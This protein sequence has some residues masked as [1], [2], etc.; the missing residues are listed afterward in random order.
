MNLSTASSAKKP[1]ELSQREQ[2]AYNWIFWLL[3]AAFEIFLFA[4][5]L[6]PSGDGPIHI[7]LSSI[8]WKLATHSSPFYAHF[9]AIR[10]L[11]QPYSFHYYLLISLEHWFTPDRAEEI[12]VGL[13]WATLAVGFRRLA[14]ELGPG[15]RSVS[16]WVFPLLLSWPLGGGFFNYVFA[17]G[18]LLFGLV[19]YT[20]LAEDRRH[21]SSLAWLA[22]VLV[23][24]VLA[25][26][27]PI[28][29]LIFLIGID[30]IFQALHHRHTEGK[31]R[32]PI[33]SV[34]AL[35]L[36]CLAFLFP[37]LIADKAEVAGS[38]ETGIRLHLGY[39]HDMVD[40]SRLA[41]FFV[42]NIFGWIYDAALV[43]MLPVCVLLFWR[44]G[45]LAR[46]RT[47]C[48]IAPDRLLL[49]SLLY[50]FCTLFFPSDMNGSALFAVRMFFMV[51]L[52]ASPCAAWVVRSRTA[53]RTIASTGLAISLLC[54]LFACLY[55]RP[56]ARS[57]WQIEHA[58]YAMVAT[59]HR[60]CR[61]ARSLGP[62]RQLCT[63]RGL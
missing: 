56:V 44:S 35:G 50:L 22:A 43:I 17:S 45:I 26:P 8:M 60:S 33:W 41:Y 2:S 11:V 47:A 48:L 10:H 36:A 5:P 54:L 21:I 9:Y 61:R 40:G 55:L 42:N 27:L 59:D 51:W 4:L 29:L 46:L 57:Q 14:I 16:L 31:L 6:M 19:Y 7:Y 25:H 49:A 37:I 34:A 20:R 39:L 18:L 1:K 13:I 28:M 38:L 52:V 58:A 24:L 12:F 32:L 30:I 23:L 62:T 3:L 63:E 53:H 15:Y